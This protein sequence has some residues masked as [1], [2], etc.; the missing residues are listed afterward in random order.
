MLSKWVV[1]TYKTLVEVALGVFFVVGGILGAT[2]GGIVNHGFIGFLVGAVAAFFGMAVFLG[3]AL[4]I[5]EIRQI[6]QSIESQLR[7]EK[8]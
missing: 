6:L 5:G 1:S 2:I 3:A 7:T 8:H 4:M